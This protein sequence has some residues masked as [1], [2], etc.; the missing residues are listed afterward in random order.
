MEKGI[1]NMSCENLFLPMPSQIRS[2]SAVIREP[3][4]CDINC[5][6]VF[7]QVGGLELDKRDVNRVVLTSTDNVLKKIMKQL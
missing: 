3:R 7:V 4:D 6:T 2:A 5:G 1:L